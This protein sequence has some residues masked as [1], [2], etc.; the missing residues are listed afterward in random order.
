MRCVGRA[1]NQPRASGSAVRPG[2]SVVGEAP[3]DGAADADS[4]PDHQVAEPAA[5]IEQEQVPAAQTEDQ[6]AQRPQ[7][8]HGRRLPA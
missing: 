5:E 8:P 4:D 7:A 3:D 6:G 2:Q 1:G